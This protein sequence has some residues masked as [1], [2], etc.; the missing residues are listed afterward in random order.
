[1]I[2]E[3]VNESYHSNTDIFEK[4]EKKKKKRCE[5]LDILEAWCTVKRKKKKNDYLL[6]FY[7]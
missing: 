3:L 5:L 4:R 1:M 2:N 6:R 7:Y